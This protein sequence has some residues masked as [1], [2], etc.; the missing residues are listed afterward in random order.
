[1][2]V[3][4]FVLHDVALHL[5]GVPRPACSR[6]E[7]ISNVSEKNLQLGKKMALL[8]LATCWQHQTC[9]KLFIS[10]LNSFAPGAIP[11]SGEEVT[12]H[13][14]CCGIKGAHCDH[15]VQVISFNSIHFN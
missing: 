8:P 4:K 13:N 5:I 11:E 3:A 12:N 14:S 7:R 6:W 1:M 10:K 2:L 9:K 15:E